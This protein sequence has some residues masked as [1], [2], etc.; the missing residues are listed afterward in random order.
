MKF[1]SKVGLTHWAKTKPQEEIISERS[2][3]FFAPAHIQ[4][5]IEAWGADGFDQRTAS[6]LMQTAAKTKN[7]LRF[8]ELSG[9]H[10]LAALHP[11]VFAGVFPQWER[12]R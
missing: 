7:W 8:K 4:K 12:V 9:L 2:K 11:L 10:E 1:T 6:F 3:F 5:R